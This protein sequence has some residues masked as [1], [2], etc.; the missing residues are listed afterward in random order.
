MA[1]MGAAFAGGWA[2]NTRF[3]PLGAT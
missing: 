1:V 3:A 2:G